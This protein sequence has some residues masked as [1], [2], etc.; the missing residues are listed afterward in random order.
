MDGDGVHREPVPPD[1]RDPVLRST[2]G[3]SPAILDR[4]PPDRLPTP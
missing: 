2:F 4:L 3:Y 1:R